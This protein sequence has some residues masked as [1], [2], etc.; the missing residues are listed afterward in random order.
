MRE[1]YRATYHVDLVFCIDT[2]GSM[3]YIIDLV[4][5]NAIQLHHDIYESMKSKGKV[6]DQMRIRVISFKD[7]IAD[8]EKAMLAS[9]FFSIPEENAHFK[10]CVDGLSADGGGDVPEDGLEALAFA[11][12]SSWDRGGTK[13]RHVIVVWSD[14]PTHP[15]GFG[16]KSKHYPEENM[17]ATFA[18]LTLWWGD[19]QV[20]GY[21]D[22]SAKRL[23]MFTPRAEEWTKITDYWDN[24][25]HVVAEMDKGLAEHE[26]EAVVA[27]ICQTI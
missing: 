8:G 12:K 25:I 17:P 14:A 21:M 1:N 19:E 26:Y 16:K 23:L 6:I 22:Q 2:T 15:I 18:D 27:A 5:N 9:D 24:V 10:E 7:Y 11:M 4:K 20:P 13:R 3:R